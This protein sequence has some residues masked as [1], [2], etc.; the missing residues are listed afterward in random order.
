[1]IK[2]E[3]SKE[4]KDAVEQIQLSDKDKE[5][6]LE[7]VLGQKTVVRKRKKLPYYAGGAVAA[8]ALVLLAAGS[9]GVLFSQDDK[10]ADTA[11]MEERDGA[12]TN[13]MGTEDYAAGADE[14]DGLWDFMTSE[15]VTS[16]SY[17]VNKSTT[18]SE[19]DYSVDAAS[20]GS[21]PEDSTSE[22][23]AAEFFRV[24]AYD[25]DIEPAGKEESF[26]TQN[27]AASMVKGDK[28]GGMKETDGK[29]AEDGLRL[30]PGKSYRAYTQDIPS[31]TIA[32]FENDG[33][34][35]DSYRIR[36]AGSTAKVITEEGTEGEA[37]SDLQ[38]KSG[39]KVCI[40]VKKA[41]AEKGCT[42]DDERDVYTGL[43]GMEEDVWEDEDI[44]TAA[45]IMI[46]AVKDNEIV[47][48]RKIYI[49]RKGEWYYGLVR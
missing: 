12:L 26:L 16:D 40:Q 13:G 34:A 22:G 35:C 15:S 38:V 5:E 39:E 46:E 24:V 11:L 14:S 21:A 33:Y 2:E 42:W 32:L 29:E 44:L 45:Q 37:V 20:E 8:A 9:S 31:C 48:A 28:N 41:A 6:L 25:E 17:E 23:F 18:E 43:D 49:G 10:K 27:E 1:M 30:E 19:A 47:G 4:Y 7:A 3:Y 36:L